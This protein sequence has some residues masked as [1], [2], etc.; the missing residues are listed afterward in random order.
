MSPASGSLNRADVPASAPS[1][2]RK[3]ERVIV[4][5]DEGLAPEIRRGDLLCFVPER[6]LRSLKRGDIVL[7]HLRGHEFARRFMARVGTNEVRIGDSVGYEDVIPLSDL[8][9][10]AT[11]CVRE[12]QERR[13]WGARENGASEPLGHRL[14]GWM[15]SL[16]LL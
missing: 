12:G 9:G 1:I 5:D 13:V 15:N 6:D 4:V 10:R 2:A 16:K 14:R 11:R 8:V 7:I 3:G